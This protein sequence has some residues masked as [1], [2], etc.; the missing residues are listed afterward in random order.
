MIAEPELKVSGFT[1]T[2]REGA[3]KMITRL[4]SIVSNLIKVMVVVIVIVVCLFKTS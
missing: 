2:I 3:K 4:I 1:L